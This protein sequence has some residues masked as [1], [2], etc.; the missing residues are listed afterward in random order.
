M[1]R[2]L[3]ILPDFW[4]SLFPSFTKVIFDLGSTTGTMSVVMRSL[5]PQLVDV[6]LVGMSV[7]TTVAVDFAKVIMFFVSESERF[8]SWC[9]TMDVMSA[10]KF[11]KAWSE[12]RMVLSGVVQG[13]VLIVGSLSLVLFLEGALVFVRLCAWLNDIAWAAAGGEEDPITVLK[14]TG[15]EIAKCSFFPC[16]LFE[17]LML[18][19]FPSVDKI[20]E[21]ILSEFLWVFMICWDVGQEVGLLLQIFF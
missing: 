6:M 8:V 4:Y 18:Q 1:M 20:R 13:L 16:L 19:A 12:Y 10:E 15:P 2:Y 9:D 7:V 11:S 21:F 17:D 14:I 5:V 3:S